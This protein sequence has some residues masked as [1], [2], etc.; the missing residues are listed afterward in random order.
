MRIKFVR[1]INGVLL[2]LLAV[3]FLECAAPSASSPIAQLLT[4]EENAQPKNIILMIGDGMG[5]A[6]VSAA[7]YANNNRLS[8]ERFP[9]IGFHKSY[10]ASDLVTD[11]AAGATAF[12]C[13]EKTYN[14][15]IG[16][17]KD[18]TPCFSILEEAEQRGMAT[19]LVA[20]ST[21]VHAT[22]ASFIAHQPIRTMYEAIAAD[23][24]DTEIDFFVGGG[25]RYFER[26]RQDDRN[27]VKEMQRKG[28]DL[29][30][31]FDGNLNS[32]TID[33]NKN[34]GFFTAD[35]DPLPVTQGRDYLPYVSRLAPNFLQKHNKDKGFF[36]MI[37][38]SQ[39]DWAGHANEGNLLLAEML[40]FD[41][42]IENVLKFAEANGE[43]LVIVTADHE[44]GGLA[45]NPK[46]KM[47]N[48]RLAFTTNGHTAALIPV[49][50][51]GP[52]SERFRG[53]YENTA[54]YHKMRQALGFEN[55][56]S[57]QD[58]ASF[59]N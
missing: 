54:I 10:S 29:R 28:Y 11:S 34:F 44:A 30:S 9:V 36:L 33:Y 25:Q 47:K 7:L 15:A 14:G 12:A 46:S 6:Q 56:N 1:R 22:P 57:M 49:Y 40:D 16:M 5:L 21:I 58:S 45:L 19:G 20:T 26:R 18:S 42:A 35:T 2:A 43:T 51:F 50:A 52:G 53:L 55:T 27:L 48:P 39:I 3:S 17:K 31:Y 32:K 59:V 38:G 37:E 13:G 8:L 41:R 4:F 23:F 24:L